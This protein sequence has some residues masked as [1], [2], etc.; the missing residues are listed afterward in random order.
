MIVVI[1][2]A[3]PRNLGFCLCLANGSPGF[4]ASQRQFLVEY[5]LLL[6]PPQQ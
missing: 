2:K 4:K 6:Q 1:P 5:W 3:Q